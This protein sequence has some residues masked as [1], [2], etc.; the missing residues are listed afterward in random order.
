MVHPRVGSVPEHDTGG[1]PAG[2]ALPHVSTHFSTTVVSDPVS[3][4]ICAK[5]AAASRLFVAGVAPPASMLPYLAT[6]AVKPAYVYG[7]AGALNIS[8]KTGCVTVWAKSVAGLVSMSNVM[9]SIQKS[10]PLVAS[11]CWKLIER[12]CFCGW[13]LGG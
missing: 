4:A 6:A 2:M 9:S 1:A 3:W 10:K 7:T 13:K 12:I 8:L 11:V 5:K